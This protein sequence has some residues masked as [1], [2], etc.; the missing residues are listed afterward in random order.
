MQADRKALLSTCVILGLVLGSYFLHRGATLSE[1]NGPKNKG[2]TPQERFESFKQLS[3]EEVIARLEG[4]PYNLT[5]VHRLRQLGD[6]K[7]IPAL[8]EAFK[9]AGARTEKQA[10]AAALVALG[11]D[12]DF[13]WEFLVKFAKRAIESEIPFPLMFDKE[14]RAIKGKFNP[15]FIAWCERNNIEP[16]DAA[17]DA[18]YLQPTDVMFIGVTGDRRAFEILLQAIR[19]RNYLINVRAAQGLA[20]LQDKRAIRPIILACDRAP[21]EIAPKI[22][23]SL[24]FFDEPEAQ[25]AAVKFIRNKAVLDS[26]RKRSR[27]K[28]SKGVFDEG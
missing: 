20:R 3:V 15:E 25:A 8:R 4:P 14:G 28:G 5:V 24:V 27:E 6:K 19:S 11:E 10:I 16:R 18:L 1:G 7:A 12:D 17:A 21:S 9:N 26:L 22:A 13:Y 23:E 2:V